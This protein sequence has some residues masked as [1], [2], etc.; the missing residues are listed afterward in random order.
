MAKTFYRLF[1]DE[2]S[3]AVVNLYS[4]KSG[5]PFVEM[6][7]LGLSLFR[8]YC[9]AVSSGKELRIVNPRDDSCYDFVDLK[10]NKLKGGS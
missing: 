1:L 3:A 5:L 2:E 7:R 10:L 4:V 8:I 6:V 9:D